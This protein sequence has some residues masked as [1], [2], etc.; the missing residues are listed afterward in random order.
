ML[1]LWLHE[2]LCTVPCPA[3]PSANIPITDGLVGHY[4]A[5]NYDQSTKVWDDARAGMAQT[6]VTAFSGAPTSG[7]LTRRGIDIEYVAGGTFRFPQQ[8]NSTDRY[9]LVYLC[10]WGAQRL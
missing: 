9:T 3:A 10:R 5:P 7:T 1:Q 6:P 4:Y 8:F 2:V